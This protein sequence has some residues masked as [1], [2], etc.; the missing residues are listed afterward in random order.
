MQDVR[1]FP[2]HFRVTV[3]TERLDVAL[4]RLY[5][6]PGAPVIPDHGRISTVVT[7]QMD[8]REGLRADLDGSVRLVAVSGYALEAG[9]D[10]IS[11]SPLVRSRSSGCAGRAPAQ[12]IAR[13]GSVVQPD[14][15]STTSSASCTRSR[16]PRPH[17]SCSE[18]SW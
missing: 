11:R 5:M 12:R 15:S 7:A 1:L 18:R 9:F 6:P 13:G 8:A 14:S 17:S 4:A 16:S 2:I 3:R 10:G